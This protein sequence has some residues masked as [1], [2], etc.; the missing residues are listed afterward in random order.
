MSRAV[1]VVVALAVGTVP[2]AVS[3]PSPVPGRLAFASGRAHGDFDIY[4]AGG[5]GA[6]PVRVTSQR[7][8]EFSPSW[9]PDGARIAV[10][11]NPLRG[12]AGDIWVMN[13]DGSGKRNL[14][15]T[16]GNAEWSPSWSP[17]GALIAYFS[18]EDGAGDVW[19]M[20]PDGSARRNLTRG[21]TT[22]NEYPT[23]SPDGSRI[24]FNAHPGNFEIYAMNADGS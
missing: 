6:R 10:R 21:V 18:A 1:A 14:T 19:V 5:D 16:P 8:D 23:W 9:S 11:V 24:A 22:L 2:A 17:D 13:A 4:V 12:D 20:H 7:R 15:R 3:A